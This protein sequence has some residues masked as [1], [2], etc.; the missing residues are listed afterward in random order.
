VGF[1]VAGTGAG[2]EATMFVLEEEFADDGFTEA[3][4]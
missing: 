4:D 2:T 1:Y 3:G